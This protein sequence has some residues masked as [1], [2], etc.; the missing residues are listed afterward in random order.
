MEGVEKDG[1][2][3]KG[4]KEWKRIEKGVEEDGRS[5]RG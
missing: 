5:G 2:S 1:R 3:E 4:W